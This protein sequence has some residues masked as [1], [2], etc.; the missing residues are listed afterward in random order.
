M[1]T[2]T[3]SK[4]GIIFAVALARVTTVV[5]TACNSD[6]D[7]GGDLNG[8]ITGQYSLATRMMTR[9][10]ENSGGGHP[11]DGKY[12]AAG[13]TTIYEINIEGFEG[14]VTFYWSTGY[15]GS[16]FPMSSVSA[17]ISLREYE[18]TDWQTG[19]KTKISLLYRETLWND[20]GDGIVVKQDYEI[21]SPGPFGNVINRG[22]YTHSVSPSFIPATPPNN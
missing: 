15:T 20:S 3:I 17:T 18:R 1:K 6:D 13:D 22:C 7:F 21:S 16:R 11:G 2:I 5:F 4:F 9:A 19:A 14:E 10:G 8:D 12:V